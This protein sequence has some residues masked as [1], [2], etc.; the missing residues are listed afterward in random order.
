[1]NLKEE[2]LNELN[3][4]SPLLAG[5][6]KTNVFSVPE[7]YFDTLTVNMLKKINFS[8][9]KSNFSVPD[10]YFDSLSTN[11]LQKIKASQDDAA[12][13]LRSISPMLYSI[14]NEN[15]FTVP[16]GYFDHL[17]QDILNKVKPVQKAKVVKLN[18]KRSI[19]KYAAAAIV[20]GVV[21]VSSLFVFNRSEHTNNSQIATYIQASKQFKNQQQ[22][23]EGIS[24]LSDDEIIKYLE[25]HS[26]D[27]DNDALTTNIK[28]NEL[29]SQ[30]DYLLNDKTLDTYLEKINAGDFQN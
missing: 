20:T 6:E 30:T 17:P 2:I 26:S 27:V 28:G 16:R 22:I 11:I 4:I 13:E 15:V 5:I 9:E 10:G 18:T 21:A 29:P 19:W 14:Q 3:D 24:K 23:N 8:E 12:Q 1:M 7:G 25:T